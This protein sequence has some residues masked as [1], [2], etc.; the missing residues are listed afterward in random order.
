MTKQGTLPNVQHD[1]L[2]VHFTDVAIFFTASILLNQLGQFK[3]NVYKL[4]YITITRPDRRI[5]N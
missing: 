2:F 5:L 3:I 1:I 4:R